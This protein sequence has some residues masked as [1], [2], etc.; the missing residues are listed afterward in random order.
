MLA[1]KFKRVGKKGQASFRVV[2]MEKRTKL[3]GRYTDD[4][5][6]FN[7]H[8]D[9]MQI[10]KEKVAHWISVGAQPTPTVWNL[11]VKS[12]AV[13]G[14]KIAVHRVSKKTE[15]PEANPAPAP[16]PVAAVAEP[17]ASAEGGSAFGGEAPKT[18]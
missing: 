1:I 6:W 15:T 14:K 18:E 4:L 10:D 3:Q 5:G 7:P 8:D 16:A 2:V 9:S 13:R 17:A 11:L 12:G